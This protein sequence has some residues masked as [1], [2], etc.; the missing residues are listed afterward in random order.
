M[1]SRNKD[2][3]I[4]NEQGTKGVLGHYLM[5]HCNASSLASQKTHSQLV[6][7]CPV[8]QHFGLDG[9]DLNGYEIRSSSC[10]IIAMVSSSIIFPTFRKGVVEGEEDAD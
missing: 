5:K 7:K 2:H 1:W 3:H 10:I 9:S 4:G 8:Q 6:K